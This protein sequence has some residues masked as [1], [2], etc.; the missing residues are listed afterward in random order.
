MRYL[1]LPQPLIAD[2]KG[3]GLSFMKLEI[4]PVPGAL[5]SNSV[6]RNIENNRYTGANDS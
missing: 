5:R 3:V 1:S 4:E 6:F 2:G